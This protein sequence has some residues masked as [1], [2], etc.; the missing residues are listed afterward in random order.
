VLAS[1]S[2]QYLPDWA[3]LFERLA[4]ACSGYMLVT[5]LPIIHA[6]ATYVFVQRPYQYGYR[7][8]YL[9]WCLN[10][11]EFLAQ[12]TSHGL[13]LVREFSV[14]FSVEVHNA[15]EPSEYRGFLFRAACR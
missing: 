14:G 2:L 1:S 12:A 4:R 13:E 15:P 7:T 9:A 10:R 11:T 5:R 8:E 6:A 3:N